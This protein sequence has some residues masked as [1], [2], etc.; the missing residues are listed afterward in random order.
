M[1]GQMKQSW[2]M[3]SWL[4]FQ[5]LYRGQ[6]KSKGK[7][8]MKSGK[9]KGRG[10]MEMSSASTV[11]SDFHPDWDQNQEGSTRGAKRKVK[12]K[13]QK[14]LLNE[15]RNDEW[16]ECTDDSDD[17]LYCDA[18]EEVEEWLQ[19]DWQD[20]RCDEQEAVEHLDEE[21][22]RDEPDDIDSQEQGSMRNGSIALSVDNASDDQDL[23]QLENQIG[24][25]CR[26][27]D[28]N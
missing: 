19:E 16:N 21:E 14:E 28:A 22:V 24:S 13:T 11:R 12:D 23:S 6:N 25:V 9:G 2:V 17:E 27:A 7:G 18:V 10:L 8:N 15:D 26:G 1:K 5:D 3:M 20:H 4:E